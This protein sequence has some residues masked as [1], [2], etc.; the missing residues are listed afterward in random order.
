MLMFDASVSNMNWQS[1]FGY[2]ITSGP[3][4][5]V[6]NFRP[7]YNN[8]VPKRNLEHNIKSVTVITAAYKQTR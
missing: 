6:F 8:T 2:P 7:S 1:G 4:K 3:I 5:A